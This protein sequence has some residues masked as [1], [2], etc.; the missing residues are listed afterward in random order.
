MKIVDCVQGTPGW[1]AARLG[2]P[3]ASNA[4]QIITAVKG[5][6]SK[7][8]RKYAHQLVADTLLGRLTEPPIGN[9]EWVARGKAL[10][11]KAVQQYEFSTDIETLPVGFITTNDGRM[12]C[13]P[14]RLAAAESG[15]Q[16][17]K[18]PMPATH[19]GYLL[20]GPGDNYR[21]QVQMQLLVC[22][23]EWIDLYSFHP[24]LPPALIRTVRDEPYIAKMRAALAEFCDMKDAMLVKARASGFFEERA[25]TAEL[26][27]ADADF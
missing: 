19:V 13:S 24:E 20:D 14:D 4:D 21:P 10:E 27:M 5:D 23:V 11:P 2:I 26:E 9:L 7:S 8:A 1:L 17:I 18:C 15:A 25:L 6:L 3:T 22:E 16:E 12:G